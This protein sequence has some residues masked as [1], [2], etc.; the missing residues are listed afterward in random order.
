MVDS[1]DVTWGDFLLG[2]T[3]NIASTPSASG[4]T[5]DVTFTLTAHMRAK[6]HVYG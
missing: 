3:A 2:M 6:L 5:S 1:I 4:G